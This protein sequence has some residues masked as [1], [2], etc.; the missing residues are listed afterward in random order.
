MS[1]SLW[2]VA[3]AV[4]IAALVGCSGDEASTSSVEGMSTSSPTSALEAIST[5]SGPPSSASVSAAPTTIAQVTTT[6]GRPDEAATTTTVPSTSITPVLRRVPIGDGVN[7]SYGRE[8]SAYPASD[9]FADCG[10][11]I[12]ASISGELLEVR[13]VDEWDPSTDNPAK[14]GG[15]SISLLG[16]D[17]VRYYM[18]HFSYIDPAIVPGA[19]VETGQLLGHVGRTGRASACHLHFSLSP[20]CGGKEWKVRRGVI[21]P[22]PYLDAWRNGDNLSPELEIYG[23]LLEHP[24]ACAEALAEPTAPDS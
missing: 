21:W 11:P 5:L 14:R 10:S 20:V 1:R 7:F 2:P 6:S 12:V 17:G 23:W 13:T 15:Q 16:D 24:N 19:H 22:W 3:V 4:S 18:A 8:H 9:I